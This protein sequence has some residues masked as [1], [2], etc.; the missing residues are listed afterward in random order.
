MS[1][2]LRAMVCAEE[3]SAF[4]SGSRKCCL[5]RAGQPGHCLWPIVPIHPQ[6]PQALNWR[7]WWAHL[8]LFRL[9]TIYRDAVHKAV[10]RRELAE[11]R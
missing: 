2:W 10:S 11:P 4:Y 1:E 8:C 9:V 6:H 3:C 7:L 5:V